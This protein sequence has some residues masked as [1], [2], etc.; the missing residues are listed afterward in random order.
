MGFSKH[1]EEMKRLYVDEKKSLNEVASV[2]GCTAQTVEYH[3]KKNKI[4]LRSRSESLK[5]RP[6]TE[7][8]RETARRLGKLL[9]GEKNPRWKGRVKRSSGY[10]A[11]R[12]TDH[13][14]AS[15]DGYV[16][17]HRLVMEEHLGR[18]LTPEEDVHHINGIKTD[19]RIENLEL[20]SKSEH[21]RLHGLERVENKTH[22]NFIYVTAEEVKE[23]IVAGGTMQDIA[24]RLSMDKTT[25]YKKIKSLGLG[26]WYK[27]W[28]NEQ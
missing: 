5:G 3:L 21:A 24:E 28:R 9:V 8:Q 13:P 4:K 18:Y 26:D 15:R 17:E 12:K 20:L 25:V 6:V 16:M 11:I 14:F 2:I 22:N 27:N 1:F 7:K 10:Y 23:A 19:N